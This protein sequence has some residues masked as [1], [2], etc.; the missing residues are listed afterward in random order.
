MRKCFTLFYCLIAVQL[1]TFAQSRYSPVITEQEV[2]VGQSLIKLQT[3]R[4]GNTS[5]TAINL[6]GNESTSIE[7]AEEVFA[8]TGGV[9]I[10]IVNPGKRNVGFLF[11]GDSIFVDPNRIYTNRGIRST[12]RNL[13]T[14]YKSGTVGEVRDLAKFILRTL[15]R[16]KQPIIA[17]HNNTDGNL[18]I[19]TYMPGSMDA[20]DAAETFQGIQHD[21]D[22]FF[23]TTSRRIFEELKARGYNVTLQHNRKVN[24]DG[25]MSVY[26]GKKGIEYTNI[27]AEHGHHTEQVGMLQALL[28]IYAGL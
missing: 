7:A 23:L 14:R 21:P 28:Q 10:K 12:L 27:E 18:S 19:Y 15:P 22:D 26:Y 13:N 6:H 3:K 24:N 11:K 17:L 20:R 2:R 5:I 8:S 25:S 16:N 1:Y 9:L 4:Y